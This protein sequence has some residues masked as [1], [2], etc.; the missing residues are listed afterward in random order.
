MTWDGKV[1]FTRSCISPAG[2]CQLTDFVDQLSVPGFVC[3][4][5]KSPLRTLSP[6]EGWKG[7]NHFC[8]K[9]SPPCL[10]LWNSKEHSCLTNTIDLLLRCQNQQL[11]VTGHFCVSPLYLSQLLCG[12]IAKSLSILYTKMQMKVAKKL[13]VKKPDQHV[14]N[15]GGECRGCLFSHSL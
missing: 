9:L 13:N 7:S 4:S 6:E 12:Q 11:L 10:F 2:K 3:K 1:Q 14:C 15:L 8:T 5:T